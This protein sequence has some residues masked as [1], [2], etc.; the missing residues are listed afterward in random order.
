MKK[1]IIISA[2]IIFL[3]QSIAAQTNYA[4][5]LAETIM[6]TY[7]DSMVVKKYASHLE[8]DKLIPAGQTAEQAQLSRPAVWNYEMGVVL[9]GFEKLATF[10]SNNKYTGYA[11]NI[12]DHFITTEGEIRTY[13]VEEYNID[14]IPAGRQ[15]LHL[16]K[17]TKEEKYKTAATLLYKQLAWQ[18]R[19]KIGG[20]WHKLKYPAQMWLD[21]LYMAQPFAVEYAVMFNDTEKFDDIINQFVWM[22]KYSRD[23]ITGLLYHGW[24][25]SKLQKW[26]NPKTGLSP[27]FWSRAM[28][29]YMMALV[30]VLDHLPA[31]YKRRAELIAIL[32]RLSTALVKFQDAKEGVWWQVT[33]KANQ[34]LNYLESSSS[35]MFL[36]ALSKA[37]NKKYIGINFKPAITKAFSGIIKK[38]VRVDGAGS[39][40]YLQAVAGAGLGGT[41]YRDGSYS[42]YVNEP[43]RDDDLKAIGP[44]I[45]ACIEYELLFP[46]K[47]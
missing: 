42:Y 45:Q 10:T 9:Q 40:H 11:K 15:L 7:K 5:K 18:P 22:E 1:L 16:Y 3:I 33:D 19:N 27:E 39:V 8:Q 26:A 29:W 20:Y 34:Q 24:D 37:V 14:N 38:F 32:N 2:V 35:A 44:F 31:N 43:K 17:N 13:N 30:D 46:Q 28:G 41:P 36:Y 25:E 23:T 47:M 21:G 4:I 12:I 6:A